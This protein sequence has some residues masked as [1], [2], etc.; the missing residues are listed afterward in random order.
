M[1]RRA[2]VLFPAAA[3]VVAA[4]GWLLSATWHLSY[5][6]GL[7]CA[8]GTATTVG[9]DAAPSSSGGRAAAVAVMLTTIPLLAAVFAWLTGRH[10]GSRMRGHLA[11]AEKRLADEAERRHRLL[12]RH[13]ELL[14][15]K[16]SADIK[17]HVS[18]VADAQVSAG[19][20]SNPAATGLAADQ[21]V[22]PPAAAAEKT[23]TANAAAEVRDASR[24]R[25]S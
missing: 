21:R 22:V 12:Q 5:G 8:A 1:K 18:A 11:A 7:Y 3:A 10:A 9:C 17:K 4:G 6:H 25:R 19:A 14:L 20:G 23:R 24:R 2:L 16:H 13:V 15:S